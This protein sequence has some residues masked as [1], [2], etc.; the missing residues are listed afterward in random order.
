MIPFRDAGERLPI[1]PFAVYALIAAN[2]VVFLHELS[3]AQ[4]CG[5][6]CMEAFITGYGAVPFDIAH[7]IAAA[8]APQPFFLTLLTSLFIH[9]G[10]LHLLGNMLYLFV[11][12]PEIEYLTGSLRFVAFYL[13]VGVIGGLVQVWAAPGSHIP[14]VGAS[15]AIA[16]VLGAY[17]LTFPTRT[18]STVV[19]IGCFP[20]FLRL[21]AI[22]VIGFWAALQFIHAGTLTSRTMSEQ[23]GV[24][25]FAHIGGFVAGLVLIAFFRIRRARGAR[26]FRYHY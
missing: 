21:P 11:F 14:T 10:W 24:G 13:V 7:G 17:L 20:L 15:G 23:G 8:G 12:G 18:I 22:I 2:V 19:P 3:L 6:V 26:R 5:T 4:A 16:G 9:A 25:Y 1:F